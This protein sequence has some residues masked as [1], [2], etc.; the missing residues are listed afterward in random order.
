MNLRIGLTEA[1]AKSSWGHIIDGMV[2][3]TERLDIWG[4]RNEVVGA[5]IHLLADRDF[6]LVLD[7]ANWLH[8]LGFCPRVRLEVRW[9]GLP[10]DVVEMLPVGYVEGDDRRRW[11]ES[12][13]R[14]GR[15]EALAHR[16]QVVYVRIRIPADLPAGLYEGQIKAFSQYGFQ[17]EQLCWQGVIRLQ[18]ADVTLPNV[19]DWSYDLDLWQHYTSLARFYRVPL[20]SEAHFAL[21]D[22]Y[23][24]S[25]AQLGQKAVTVVATEIPW[26][27]QRCFRDPDYPSYLFEHAIIEVVRDEHGQLRFNYDHLDRLLSLAARHGIDREI[28]I[29]GLLNIWQDEAFGLGKIAP[30]APDALR[31]RCYDQRSGAIAYLRTADELRL[32]IRALQDHLAQKGL[33]ERVRVVADEPADLEAFQERLAFV[34]QAAP[35]F[36]YKA[37]INHFE[38]MQEA[39]PDLVDAVP[40]LPLACRNPDLTAQW[41]DQLRRRGGRMLWYVCCWPPIPNTF[42]H[43]P[44]VEGQLH[45]WLTWYLGLDGFLRWAFCLWPADPWQRVSWRAPHWNAGDMFFVLPGLDGYPVE[46]LRYE[47]MRFAAQDYEL[48]KLVERTLPPDQA[49]A[50]TRRA[51]AHI[52]YVQDAG[53]L[54]AV[55][56]ARPQD[57]YS[58][59][60]ADY[61]AARRVLLDALEGR[62]GVGTNKDSLLG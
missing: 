48:L 3:D 62:S 57:L 11:P 19:A 26:S 20:W 54:A 38:F 39:P 34:R 51:L 1:M 60:P 17:D 44:L 31:V 37:A 49:Q 27:G 29:V 55:A 58:L 16:P 33:I 56:T 18:V 7:R 9:P 46:T 23:Q 41:A 13:E 25:L 47:A 24:A 36:K 43:S 4:A 40:V 12:L 45:G 2:P 21:I 10:A 52:L 6:V 15:A 14:S 59:Q 61:Q 50:A 28:E 22:R 53:D 35:L 30:D 8:A 5:Q 42:I 32:F